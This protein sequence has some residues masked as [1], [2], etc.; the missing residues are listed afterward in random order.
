LVDR[1]PDRE[2]YHLRA[3]W[4]VAE[5][6]GLEAGR[7]ILLE[8]EQFYPDD[9]QMLY[10]IGD[11]SF[12][13]SEYPLAVRYLERVLEHDPK[14][15]RAL[16]HLGRTY[17]E[18]GQGEAMLAR[19]RRSAAADT[20]WESRL[21]L[22]EAMV[23]TGAVKPG[24]ELMLRGR[25]LHPD[26]LLEFTLALAQAHAFAGEDAEAEADWTLLRDPS[27][28]TSVQRQG[29]IHLA[30]WEA[31]R[32]RYRRA[33]ALVERNISSARLDRDST[34]EALARRDRAMLMLLGWNDPGPARIE[35]ERRVQYEHS[36]TYQRPYY[37][38]WPYWGGLLKLAL[39]SGMTTQA[40][41]LANRKF[42]MDKWYGPYVETYLA[43]TK[44]Q[45]RQA[46]AA[47]SGA[48]VWGPAAENVELL[49]FL[50]VSQKDQGDLQGS[51]ESLL[52]LLA[53]RSNLV[54]ETPYTAKALLL[55]GQVQEEQGRRDLALVSY[56][57]LAER[58]RTA[59]DDL[60]DRKDLMQ[61]LRRL[62]ALHPPR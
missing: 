20:S 47:G 37:E 51:A 38:Y 6:L 1:I 45:W 8:M 14:F 41:E 46:E 3:Q 52:R 36:I 50:A 34:A 58:W 7:A 30:M 53:M 10:G 18:L 60:P 32:G 9:K 15:V 24:I 62:R 48:L 19:A 56:E 22:G 29:T 28:P 35:V 25:A 42:A 27:R 11:L 40:E 59:D 43:C 26:R 17:R 21:L 12:H 61:R 5:G 57:K 44:G 49:H 31:S 23:A 4:A 2:R 54:P 16:Q 55:L 39:S 13:L 33:A